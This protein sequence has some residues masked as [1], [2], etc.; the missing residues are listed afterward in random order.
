MPNFPCLFAPIGPWIYKKRPPPTFKI[1]NDYLVIL[2]AVR[3]KAVILR[4]YKLTSCG[5][6]FLPH[7]CGFVLCDT[8]LIF[9]IRLS[10]YDVHTH[11]LDTRG[12]EPEQGNW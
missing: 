9:D 1:Q 11:Q 3:L 10:C 7:G 4:P 2:G 8:G 6:V 5:T 12:I